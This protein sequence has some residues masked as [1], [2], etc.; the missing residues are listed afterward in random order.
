MKTLVC[1]TEESVFSLEEIPEPEIGKNPY[2]PEDV[3]IEVKF[4][5]IC[6][7]EVNLWKEGFPKGALRAKKVGLGHE[8]AGVVLAA[9]EKVRGIDKGDRV[10]SEVSFNSC[11]KCSLC[12]SGKNNLCKHASA[13]MLHQGGFSKLLPLPGKNIH[14][15]PSSVTLEEA[16]LC[17]PLAL[18]VNAVE[19]RGRL[20]TGESIAIFGPGPIGLC[21]V[22]LARLSG[23]WPVI[24]IGL[25][26]DKKRLEAAKTL[27]ADYCINTD[28]EDLLEK[29]DDITVKQGIDLVIEIAGSGKAVTQALD[30]VKPCGRVVLTGA[31]YLPIE[32]DTVKK[33]ML[34]QIDLLGCRGDPTISWIKA[35][36]ILGTGKLNLR[37]IITDILP[38][39]RW[40]EGFRFAS[41]KNSLKVLLQ[42]E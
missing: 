4:C 6:G 23:A 41:S 7:T 11:G 28:E 18:A 20:K 21:M 26:A 5:G 15:I 2:R 14:K 40:E 32:I 25:K 19:I 8:V 36:Q 37:P 13:F 34:R 29:I 3:I 10:V 1:D 31:G 17:Q 30:I 12:T 39:G 27:G 38:L 33:I 22:Q 16:S 9:G 24:V 42:P 35:L